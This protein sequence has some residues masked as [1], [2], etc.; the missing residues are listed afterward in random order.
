VSWLA[1]LGCFAVTCVPKGVRGHNRE[2][3]AHS[4]LPFAHRGMLRAAEVMAGTAWDLLTN[5]ALLRS[6]RAEF[7]RGTK[8]FR[9]DPLIPKKQR[10]PMPAATR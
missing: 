2:Y 7:V 6:V 8:G 3:T 1:P 5:P 4:N 10:P 9:Y